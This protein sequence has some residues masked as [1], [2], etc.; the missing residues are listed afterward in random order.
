MKHITFLSII[1]AISIINGCRKQNNTIKNIPSSIVQEKY[2][3]SII[4]KKYHKNGKVESI[5]YD[6]NKKKG[7]LVFISYSPE[8]YIIEKQLR[9]DSLIVTKKDTCLCIFLSIKYF[10]NGKIKET[11]CQGEYNSMGVPVGTWK[12]FDS[13]GKVEESIYYHPDK[14]G[15][16][17]KIIKKYNQKGKLIS[18]KTYNNDIQY[19]NELIELKKI[20]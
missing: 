5:L 8:G 20:P 9:K 17:Y 19:E 1:S 13:L 7:E 10:S 18:E 15:N 11:G 6:K 12:V 16:D 4:S 3:D 2:D 14:F